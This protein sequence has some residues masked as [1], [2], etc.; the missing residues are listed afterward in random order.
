MK[1]KFNF[2]WVIKNE[3]SSV[4]S[5]KA[6]KFIL[7]VWKKKKGVCTACEWTSLLLFTLPISFSGSDSHKLPKQLLYIVPFVL[8]ILGCSPLSQLLYGGHLKGFT[9]LGVSSEKCF[10]FPIQIRC[11][12]T[13]SLLREGAELHHPLGAVPVLLGGIWDG[14]PL[15]THWL[16]EQKF[17]E[18]RSGGKA[19]IRSWKFA[20]LLGC[21][22]VN[23]E[24]CL[25]SC[26][27]RLNPDFKQMSSGT[28]RAYCFSV[29]VGFGCL[30][31]DHRA[32]L[33]QCTKLFLLKG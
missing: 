26:C 20:F 27:L 18:G 4:C 8:P 33:L 30:L 23:S 17:P 12:P 2:Q 5:L 1:T 6:F 25:W 15:H 11:S 22:C 19:F 28:K 24:C 9:G 21:V 32:G 13:A 3:F 14:E 31:L 16:C 10:L 29:H 7:V